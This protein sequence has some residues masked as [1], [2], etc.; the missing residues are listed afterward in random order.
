MTRRVVVVGAGITGLAAA[1]RLLAASEPPEVVVLESAARPG[2]RVASVTVGGLELEAGPDS[3]LARKLEAIELCRE[4]GLGNALVPAAV[5]AARLWTADGLVPFPPGP[6]GIPTSL[7][8]LWGRPRLGVPAKLRASLDLVLPRRRGDADESLAS[9]LHR[10]LGRRASAEL[11]EP[12]LG[13]V[14]GGDVDRLS[15]AATFP[16]LVEW[17][18]GRGSLIRGACGAAAAR[19][20]ASVG[21]EGGSGTSGTFLSVRGGLRRLIDALV[22]VL[23][24][25]VRTGTAATGLERDGAGFALQA[26]DAELEADGVIVTTPAAA[27]AALVADAEPNVARGLAQLRS[28]SSAVVPLVYPDGTD[29]ALPDSSGFVAMPGLLP[30]SAATLVSRKWPEPAFGDR[31]VIRAFVPEGPLLD[32]SDDEVIAAAAGALARVYGLPREPAAATVVRWS[33]A[34]PQY[35]VGHLDR[36]EAIRATLPPGLAVAGA[37]LGGVGIP[38]CI[39]QGGEAADRVAAILAR[40]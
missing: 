33:D 29:A 32:R 3:F 27:A 16:E 21:G 1:H 36:V 14:L 25:R 37:A 8:E 34:M 26:G 40:A 19:R 10:R 20:P 5:A 11:V 39:R 2:G 15:A 7:G 38:D 22:D 35:E 4:L 28:T 9:L 6:L 30:I 24:E 23:G 12:L 18:R 13:G 31:A 17:E